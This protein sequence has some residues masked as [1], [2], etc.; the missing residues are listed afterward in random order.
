M[1]LSFNDGQRQFLKEPDINKRGP[2]ACSDEFPIKFGEGDGGERGYCREGDLYVNPEGYRD[3]SAHSVM[4]VSELPPRV[5]KF[6]LQDHAFVDEE[7]YEFYAES[8]AAPAGAPLLNGPALAETLGNI[9]VR[10]FLHDMWG[11]AGKSKNPTKGHFHPDIH[12]VFAAQGVREFLLMPKGHNASPQEILN[13]HCQQFVRT[14]RNGTGGTHPQNFNEAVQVCNDWL[15]HIRTERNENG[16]LL[17]ARLV[18]M[19]FHRREADKEFNRVCESLQGRWREYFEEVVRKRRS[20]APF[21]VVYDPN[22][23]KG[24]KRVHCLNLRWE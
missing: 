3:S 24:P 7:C 18:C 20:G 21:T 17:K 19:A 23:G 14:W 6:S 13:G 9:G 16:E 8:Q 2:R 10:Y 1:Q 5:V 4:C 22:D 11:R 15:Q 12:R